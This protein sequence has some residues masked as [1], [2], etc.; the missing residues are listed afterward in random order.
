VATGTVLVA[1]RVAGRR[2][3]GHGLA[4]AAETVPT[5]GGEWRHGLPSPE[6]R[7][8][9]APDGTITARTNAIGGG[10]EHG[11]CRA[12]RCPQY[13]PHCR[14]N[15]GTIGRAGSKLKGGWSGCL[16]ARGWHGRFARPAGPLSGVR[17]AGWL[18][19]CERGRH[20]GRSGRRWGVRRLA[21]LSR[22]AATSNRCAGP[23][24]RSGEVPRSRR[25]SAGQGVAK[26]MRLANHRTA[27]AGGLSLDY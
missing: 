11:S 16:T 24:E 17:L 9:S 19:S 8:G 26:P 22:G 7:K 23:G 12:R 1:L 18:R 6:S 10:G 14:S 15:A 3:F 2:S 13:A 5:A 27:R 25:S 20:Q 4:V 21:A